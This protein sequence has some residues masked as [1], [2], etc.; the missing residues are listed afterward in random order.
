MYD[1][2]VDLNDGGKYEKLG[3]MYTR[4]YLEYL[5]S[6]VEKYEREHLK[7]EDLGSLPYDINCDPINK[8]LYEGPHLLPEE[9]GNM[10]ELISGKVLESF[11]DSGAYKGI[12]RLWTLPYWETHKPNPKTIY[13]VKNIFSGRCP[14]SDEEC[15]GKHIHYR[16]PRIPACELKPCYALH[17][18]V[19]GP[20]YAKILGLD[21]N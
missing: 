3:F 5:A 16:N 21:K 20:D 1:L 14:Y 18:A 17:E 6:T 12:I 10:K 4:D 11:L 2:D 13:C 8:T 9:G 19:L 7:E 15:P